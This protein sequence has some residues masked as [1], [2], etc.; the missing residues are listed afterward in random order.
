MKLIIKKKTAEMLEGDFRDAFALLLW[1]DDVISRRIMVQQGNA[2]VSMR[3]WTD[4]QKRQLLAAGIRLFSTFR[5]VEKEH[6][7]E[8]GLDVGKQRR[9]QVSLSASS[10]RCN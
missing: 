7:V 5:Q 4:D 1:C 2:A 10:T 9:L 8:H 3:L 6:R